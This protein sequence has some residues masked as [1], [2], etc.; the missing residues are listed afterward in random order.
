MA[1]RAG[2]PIGGVCES[3]TS[4]TVYLVRHG[5]HTSLAFRRWEI[6]TGDWPESQQI[7]DGNY[8][9]V[10]WGDADYLCSRFL[11]P[12]VAVKAGCLPSRSAIHVVGFAEPPETFFDQS[13][14]IEIPVSH[15]QMRALC[16]YIHESYEC[17]EQGHPIRLGDPRYGE[18]GIYQ[19]DGF[20]YVPKTCNVWTARGLAAAELPVL[21]PLCTFADPLVWQTKSFG[22]ETQKGGTFLPVIYPFFN[23]DCPQ[24]E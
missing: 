20:Y 14:V 4:P 24:S 6:S 7:P 12:L 1:R 21:T 10:G 3:E 13:Q 18:G 23:F 11:N 5:W 17:D 16:R 15:Q 9:E 2:S 22:N 8:L 19:S